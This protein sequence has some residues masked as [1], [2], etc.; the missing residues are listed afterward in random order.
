[1][2]ELGDASLGGGTRIV[3]D[4]ID[5]LV[6]KYPGD[7]AKKIWHAGHFAAAPIF[8]T[9]YTSEDQ[10]LVD[11][12]GGSVAHGL[13]AL[14]TLWTA[15]AR[16]ASAENGYVEDDVIMLG[17]SLFS[18]TPNGIGTWA[19]ATHFGWECSNTNPRVLDKGGDGS[20]TNFTHTKWKLVFRAWY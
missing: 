9:A 7:T 2:C 13:A 16:C 20:N 1:V 14:P 6:A 12:F 5:E 3:S 8:T 11:S 18:S 19:N 4:G 15:H 10:T 17:N